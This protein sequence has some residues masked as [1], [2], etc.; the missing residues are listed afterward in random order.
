MSLI[1]EEQWRASNPFDSVWV[2]ASAGT[3]KTKVLTDRVLRL[4]LQAAKP[5]RI[6]CLTFTKA[7]AAEMENRINSVLKQ[8]AVCPDEDLQKTLE[9]LTQEPV[10]DQVFQNARR[11]FSHVLE[12]PGGMKIMTIHSF[13]QSLLKR[14][15]LEADVPPHFEVIDDLNA[16]IMQKQIL[17]EVLSA[18]DFK[19]ILQKLTY[20]ISTNTLLDLFDR[21]LNDTP[22]LLKLMDQ[23][24]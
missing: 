7:A 15:P 8:W 13:C 1:N 14:F 11:L 22:R 6:L 3:G 12:T 4:L 17:N 5:E 18:S 20:I 10:D 9:Q 23:F 16:K 19:S 21:I 2:S 24:I